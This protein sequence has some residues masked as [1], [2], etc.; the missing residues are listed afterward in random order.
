MRYSQNKKSNKKGAL[1]F[2]L[3]SSTVV[4]LSQRYMDV[5][6]TLL[7]YAVLIFIQKAERRKKK[8]E[9]EVVGRHITTSFR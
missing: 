8:R 4:I 9:N 3:R 7:A 1:Y 6:I 5:R 2:D